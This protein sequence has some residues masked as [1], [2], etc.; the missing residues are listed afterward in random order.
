M[1]SEIDEITGQVVDI[2][3]R[4]HSRIGPGLVE[5]VYESVMAK[6]LERRGLQVI[7]QYTAPIEIDG[8]CYERAFAADLF[9]DGQLVVEI[10][11]MVRTP[12][13]HF[14]QVLTYIRLLNLPVGLLLN[15]GYATMKQGIHR[16][17]NGYRP[18][19]KSPLELNRPTR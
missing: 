14:K 9:V 2:A 11:S 4:L 17:V 5:N 12:A 13:V 7:R 3:V 8:Q 6:E 15:F 16:I 19:A 10:K 1:S 18:S